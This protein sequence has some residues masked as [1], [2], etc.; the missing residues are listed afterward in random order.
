MTDKPVALDEYPI[1]QSTASL[2][3]VTTSDRNF[4]NRCY[5]NAHDRTGDIFCVT[6]LGVYPNQGVID[7]YFTVRKGDRQWVTRASDTLHDPGLER[8]QPSVGPIHIEV[9]EPLQRLR[10]IVDGTGDE[11]AAD[12][13]FTG[14]FPAIMEQP[15][16]MRTGTRPIISASRFAQVGTWEGTLA[17]DGTE[18]NV[19]PDVWLGTRDRSW[20]IRPT[21]E[22]DPPDRWGAT[23]PID[24]F[25]WTYVPLR[26][27]DFAL[28]VIVQERSDGFRILN[29]ATRV[30]A[31]GRV[32]QLGWPDV[33]I[34]YTPGTRHPRSARLMLQSRVSGQFVVEIDTLGFVPLNVGAGYSGDPD[35]NHGQFKGAHWVDRAIYDLSD[36]TI[37]G[38]IPFSV[39]DHVAHAR[40]GDF[41][42]W[43]MFEHGTFGRHDPSGFADWDSVA[44]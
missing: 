14:S 27:D 28:I 5:F 7:A 18:I 2:R 25:W 31:D 1:H 16:V 17:V 11:L 24:G 22:P 37:T 40:I 26:F 21:G 36:P 34:R 19:E 33:A 23:D 12:L 32:E 6:G 9:I 44:N 30:F 10:V 15:H 39:V 41:E 13:T 4:Y 20:G 8:L 29:D 43:G 3:H 42:G 38:R 35:W